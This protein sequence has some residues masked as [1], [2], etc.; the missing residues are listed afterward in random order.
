MLQYKCTRCQKLKPAEEFQRWIYG[1]MWSPSTNKAHAK[2]CNQ[3]R[4]EIRQAE[5]KN[6]TTK[7]RNRK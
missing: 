3:C 5:A 4:E 7:R 6:N 2:R 1:P